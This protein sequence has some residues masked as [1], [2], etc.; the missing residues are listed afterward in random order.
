MKT[1]TVLLGVLSIVFFT[2]CSQSNN[3]SGGA[4]KE[5]GGISSGGGGTLPATPIS[6]Q[7]VHDVV[8]HARKDLRLLFRGQQVYRE[9]DGVRRY[10]FGERNLLTALE[11]VS[12]EVK[13]WEP[14]KDK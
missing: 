3:G 11:T 13:D 6:I 4:P 14:C 9:Q 7:D 12:V 2:A 5:E 10:F 8:R 1:L